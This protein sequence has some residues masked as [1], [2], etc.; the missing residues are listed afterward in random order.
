[1]KYTKMLGLLAVAAVALMAVAGTASAT[2]TSP[3]GTVYN[4]KLH[5]TGTET[6]LHGSVTLTCKHSTIEG[7]VANG[8]TTVPLTTFTFNECGP[9]T[10][11]TIKPG[12]LRIE[13]NGTVFSE[14]AEVTV[15]VHR[16]VLGFPITTH[17]IYNT[18]VNP[19]TDIGTLVEG[20]NA[21]LNIGSAAIPRTPTDGACGETSVLT[22]DFHVITPNPLTVD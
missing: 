11:I 18:A 22:G 19:G 5:L 17:C 15:S 3:A 8:A 9:D 2:I 6:T 14:G 7:T 21:T 16:T 10:Y 1:M 13:S 20:N 12:Y 4:G